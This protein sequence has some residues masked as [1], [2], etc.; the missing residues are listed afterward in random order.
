MSTH[1][2]R[3]AS[4]TPWPKHQRSSPKSNPK[5]SWAFW[6]RHVRQCNVCLVC[7]CCPDYPMRLF[8]SDS[9]PPFSSVSVYFVAF[10]FFFETRWRFGPVS[11]SPL[12]NTTSQNWFTHPSF[13]FSVLLLLRHHN[14]IHPKW[15][16]RLNY[17]PFQNPVSTQVTVPCAADVMDKLSGCPVKNLNLCTTKRKSPKRLHGPRHGDDFIRRTLTTDKRKK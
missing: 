16:S 1:T 4:R 11:V 7:V 9:G 14:S 10:F 3:F 2:C 17:V 12:H 15:W 13:S 8:R 5:K 6:T